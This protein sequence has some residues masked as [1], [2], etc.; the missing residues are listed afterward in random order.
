MRREDNQSEV[1]SAIAATTASA[2][3]VHSILTVP[4]VS[5]ASDTVLEK[6]ARRTVKD[7]LVLLDYF[8]AS[9]QK[10]GAAGMVGYRLSQ[11]TTVGQTVNETLSALYFQIALIA[12]IYG[13]LGLGILAGVFIYAF[14]SGKAKK[15][16]WNAIFLRNFNGCRLPHFFAHLSCLVGGIAGFISLTISAGA[17]N[18]IFV[19]PTSMLLS[20]ILNG[21]AKPE[22]KKPEGGEN[23]APPQILT[24][25]GSSEP[26]TFPTVDRPELREPA[27]PYSPRIFAV[28]RS[29]SESVF[30]HQVDSDHVG[31]QMPTE[32]EMVTPTSQIASGSS[33]R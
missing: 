19:L 12:F 26:P 32:T 31:I 33:F 25:A 21:N 3:R 29:R 5:T 18:G 9:A 15:D 7:F 27:R 10:T 1:A 6:E 22:E 16:G 30:V 8:H 14:C 23:N 24:G 20:S 11:S 4:P 28:P 17:N 13:I 2:P